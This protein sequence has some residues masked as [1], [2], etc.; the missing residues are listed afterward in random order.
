MGIRP[1][2]QALSPSLALFVYG[3]L[4]PGQWAFDQFCRGQVIALTP[5]LVR[6]RLYQLS[7]GYPALSREPGWVQGVRLNLARQDSLAAID[8]FE[9]YDPRCPAQSPYQRRWQPIYRLDRTPLSQAW[10]YT[11]ELNQIQT[12][13]GQWLPEGVWP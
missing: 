7:L 9:E 6:G 10:V 8:A 4:K 13:G 12:Y 5:A 3:T 11:M 1:L 2:N